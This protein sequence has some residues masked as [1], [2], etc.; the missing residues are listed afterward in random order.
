MLLSKKGSFAF[1]TLHQKFIFSPEILVINWRH[2]S[3][4]CVLKQTREMWSDYLF[5]SITSYWSVVAVFWA[6][7]I[8]AKKCQCKYMEVP[9]KIM[10]WYEVILTRLVFTNSRICSGHGKPAKSWNLRISFSRPGKSWNLI[11][12]F[13]PWKSWKIKVLFGSLVTTDD[14]ARIMI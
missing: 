7:V 1:C 13:E 10:Y 6:N 5:L 4:M 2:I 3:C 11:I 14:K 8:S 12:I 9:A